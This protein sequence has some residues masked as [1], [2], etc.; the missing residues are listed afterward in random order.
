[1]RAFFCLE[2]KAELKEKLSNISSQLTRADAHVSWVKPENLHITIKFLGEISDGLIPNLKALAREAINSAKIEAPVTYLFDHLGAFPNPNR[3]KVIWVGSKT[4]SEPLQ[5]LAQKLEQALSTIGF[6]KERD[7]FVTHV[8]V[9]R[10]KEEG[11]GV[12][13]LIQ[14]MQKIEPFE[15]SAQLDRL[16][17][18][19]S[20]LTPGGSIYTPVFQIPFSPI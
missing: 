2:L 20:D 15:F 5:L 12:A 9:G 11:S 13:K 7:H 6:A 18:M 19:K 8:T 17:L 1:M 14:V 10:L 3:P 4:E 16:T